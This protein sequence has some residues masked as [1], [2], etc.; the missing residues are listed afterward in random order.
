MGKF[1]IQGAVWDI[2]LKDDKRQRLSI[3]R[4]L[5]DTNWCPTAVSH[6]WLHCL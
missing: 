5:I 6:K 3:L 1:V 4:Y 2:K